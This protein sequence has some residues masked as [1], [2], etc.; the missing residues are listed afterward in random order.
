[1]LLFTFQKCFQT[2]QILN[3]ILSIYNFVFCV[4]LIIIIIIMCSY[5]AHIS[6]SRAQ[7]ALQLYYYPWSLDLIEYHSTPW[8]AYYSS[9][10]QPISAAELNT[11]HYNL[12]PT[13]YPSLLGGEK[14]WEVKCLA[15][16]HNTTA[17]PGLEPT[18]L[19]SW[20][21][22]SSH[23]TMMPSHHPNFILSLNLF[24]HTLL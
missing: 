9:H 2:I 22:C 20:V 12:C 24:I 4:T 21:H 7:G 14:Q 3:T 5:I 16:G 15:Q 13:R 8:G 6:T 19:W 23:W 10:V 17:M 1:M 18:I 11:Q